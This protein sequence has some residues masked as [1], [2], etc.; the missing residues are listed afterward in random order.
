M[1]EAV[2]DETIEDDGAPVGPNDEEDSVF[3]GEAT[4]SHGGSAPVE[5]TAEEPSGA[6]PA[7]EELVKRIPENT[8]KTMDELFRAKFV[9]VQRVPAKN[10]KKN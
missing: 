8:L 9:R 4:E 1:E 6:L 2:P 3:L 5:T 10:L 7:L